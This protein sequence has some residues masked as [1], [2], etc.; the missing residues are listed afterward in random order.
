[1]QDMKANIKFRVP[2]FGLRDLMTVRHYDLK[3]GLFLSQK[4]PSLFTKERT[5]GKR[6]SKSEM[7]GLG[8]S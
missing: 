8:E 1:M 7:K 5:L 4:E 6:E 3:T 2:S